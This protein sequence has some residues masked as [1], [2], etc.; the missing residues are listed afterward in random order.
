[1][2]CLSFS[3]KK[4]T[5]DEAS[6][7]TVK[8]LISNPL[9]FFLTSLDLSSKDPCFLNLLISFKLDILNLNAQHFD[10]ICLMSCLLRVLSHFL[11]I[12]REHYSVEEATNAD[13]P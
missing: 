6:V 1:M 7:S 5:T 9:I 10:V 4:P 12:L 13:S 8:Y 3:F 2:S 11:L